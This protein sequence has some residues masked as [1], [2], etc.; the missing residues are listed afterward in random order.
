MTYSFCP[1]SSG[2]LSIK[3][4]HVAPH[5]VALETTLHCSWSNDERFPVENWR[6]SHVL[7]TPRTDP[8][9]HT[10]RVQHFKRT[11]QKKKEKKEGHS[12]VE[13][14]ETGVT[15]F[16]AKR[17]PGHVARHVHYTLHPAWHGGQ[18]HTTRKLY[19]MSRAWRNVGQTPLV[20]IPA[21]FVKIT[22]WLAP[23]NCSACIRDLHLCCTAM[24]IRD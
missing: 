21:I 19:G 16:F 2:D 4:R 5:E 11:R 10:Q 22:N 14:L 12:G 1:S 7:V 23:A 6:N 18:G 9:K 15:F 17:I 8:S 24:L 20:I 13:K 3:E